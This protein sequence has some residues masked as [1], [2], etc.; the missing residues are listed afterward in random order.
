MKKSE[1]YTEVNWELGSGKK[2]TVTIEMVTEK[3]INTD[4]DKFNIKTCEIDIVAKVEGMGVVGYNL[5]EKD[6]GNGIVATIGKLG[7]TADNLSRI[8]AAMATFET[9]PEWAAKIAGE[10][11]ATI[12]EIEYQEHSAKMEKVMGQ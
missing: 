1:I 10:R 11:A 12:D 5:I 6:M 8:K 7:I 4:G 9:T 2:A 3:A